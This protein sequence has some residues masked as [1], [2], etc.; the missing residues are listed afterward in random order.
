MSYYPQPD[1]HIREKVKVVLDL[2]NY[3]T[4]KS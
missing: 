3:D 4:K 2:P 1:S